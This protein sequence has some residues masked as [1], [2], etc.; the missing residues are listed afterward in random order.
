M[1]NG[2]GR[3]LGSLI[4]ARPIPDKKN[5]KTDQSV[6]KDGQNFSME[7]NIDLIKANKLQPRERFVDSELEDLA[8]SIKEYG[9]LQP[10]IVSKSEDGFELIAGE[11]R[12]RAAR[13]AGLKKIPIIIRNI[14]EQKKLEVALVEN[15]Q[16]QDLNPIEIA[17]GYKRLMDEFNL[18]APEVSQKV[19]K[20]RSSVANSLR[21]LSLPEEIQ[22]AMI[23]GQISEGHGKYLAGL[24]TEAKQLNLFR[25]ILHSSLS[26]EASNKEARRMGGTK[27]A[28]IKINYRD[29]DKEFAL[30][31]F[32]G[33]KIEIKRKRKGGQII[34][35]FYGD[36]ELEEIVKKVKK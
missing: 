27:L 36:D 3:G 31:E 15:I 2:L 13:K 16:R 22:L 28:R 18:K 6:L 4:S 26:V 33:A 5:I 11:R 35:D 7:I 24:E 23:N 34:I 21:L 19:G 29:K 1:P 12:L 20:P 8:Q 9:I 30:R 17:K 14:T 10:L 32:F 25:K